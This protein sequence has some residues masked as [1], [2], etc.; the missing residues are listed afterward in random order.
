MDGVPSVTQCPIAP[1]DTQ[2]YKWRATQY[3]SSWYHSHFSV[4]AWDGVFGGI[5]IN[6]PATAN[7]DVD[8]GHVFL[9]DWSHET[10][11]VLAEQAATT[12]PPTS[13][14]ALINGTNTWTETDGTVVGSRFET[15]FV[16]GT[17]YRMRLVNG[18]ADTHFRFTIDN[19]TLEVISSDF[20][21]I[22][23]YNTTDISIGMGQRY[24]VIVTATETTG[25]FWLRAIPQESCSDNNNVDNIL[26]IVR[27]DSSSTAD[28]TST[29]YST[30]VDSC[31]DESAANLAPFLA[32]DVGTVADTD[33][34]LASLSFTTSILWTMNAVSFVSEWSYPTVEA[35]EDGNTTWSTAEH[36]WSLPTADEWVMMVIQVSLETL[37]RAA[38]ARISSHGIL[39]MNTN[40][41]LLHRPTS[42]RP[43]PSTCTAT[44][45]GC[46]APETAPTPTPPRCR[47]SARPVATSPCSPAPGGWPWPGRRTTPAPGSCTVRPNALPAPVQPPPPPNLSPSFPLPLPFLLPPPPH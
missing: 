12:G 15:N 9:N 2:T 17:R 33:D 34:E 36:V 44:T 26:G 11:D 30:L 5:L 41:K 32:I 10:A 21:P 8:L 28:P 25:D 43:T 3:G 4:Q 37:L 27:Y 38:N 46:S 7:Y 20:V 29:A 14:N 6:G 31:A 45:S 19:H 42:L 24:D 39:K 35:I 22:V 40:T 16:A 1:G 47:P 13:D 23:P 18:A